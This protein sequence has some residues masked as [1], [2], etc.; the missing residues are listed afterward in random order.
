MLRS[1]FLAALALVTVLAVLL[2]AYVVYDRQAGQRLAATPD[3]LFP[4][5]DDR[6]NDVARV[7]VTTP[8]EAF[9]IE[10]AEGERWVMPEKDGYPVRFETIKQAVVGM[11]SLDPLEP[12]TADPAR[13]D[14]LRVVDPQPDKEVEGEGSL[15]RLL[16]GDGQ[17]I[18][19]VIVGK[20]KSVPTTGREGWYYVRLPSEARTWLAEGR[21]EVFEKATAWLDP[22]M[23][24]V[25]RRRVRQVVAV[26]QA[27]EE[28][29]VE[30]ELP[31][32]ADF[33][34][35]NLPEDK[36]P[37]HGAAGNALGS[38]LGFLSFEDARQA[39]AVDFGGGRKVIF[40]T[41]DGLVVEVDMLEKDGGWWARYQARAEPEA[42][43]LE[44][45]PE[46][47]RAELKPAD[48]VAREAEEINRR[49]AGWAYLLPEYKA[50]DF[51][52]DM[53]KVAG[54]KEGS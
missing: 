40:R 41:F 11:A 33:A 25:S 9:T 22:A 50:K 46:D 39:S 42:S 47:E 32:T 18:G 44:S 4:G 8:A 26:N 10:R 15:L 37:L 48:E 31:S 45:L 51:A 43:R 29:I 34:I 1:R 23:P 5:L 6:I 3:L 54:P 27:G 52:T 2:A 35:A 12:R 38:S 17:V 20:T 28:V 49:Y 30:R 14:R 19:A 13:Y 16:G 36:Q 7:E 53:D 21:I 24:T